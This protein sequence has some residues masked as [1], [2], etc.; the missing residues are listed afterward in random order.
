[1]LNRLIWKIGQGMGGILININADRTKMFVILP[2]RQPK[3]NKVYR[4]SFTERKTRSDDR[5]FIAMPTFLSDI[6]AHLMAQFKHSVQTGKSPC[7]LKIVG[8]I[9]LVSCL[10]WGFVW[11]RFTFPR[12][13][14]LENCNHSILMRNPKWTFSENQQL[15]C[16]KIGIGLLE[17][18]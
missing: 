16:T 6:W 17:E 1:M 5:H 8:Q 10:G 13:T 4:Y 14:I 15:Y 7:C 18:N 12:K 2:L 3:R 9:A 11:F